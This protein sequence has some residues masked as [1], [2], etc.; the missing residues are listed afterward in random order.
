MYAYMLRIHDRTHPNLIEWHSLK[1]WK[2]VEEF[3]NQL[4][5]IVH[6][7]QRQQIIKD[8]VHQY[9]ILRWCKR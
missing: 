6:L 3:V 7:G 2:E 9:M 4:F 8:S 1:C 5:S